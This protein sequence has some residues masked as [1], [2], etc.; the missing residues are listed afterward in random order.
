V[1]FISI[2]SVII[3]VVFFDACMRCTRLCPLKPGCDSSPSCGLRRSP[4]GPGGA[5]PR[6]PAAL[7]VAPDGA[8]A[9]P[10]SARPARPPGVLPVA[11][12]RPPASRPASRPRAARWLAPHVR[13]RWPR[14]P[15]A[16][17]RAPGV[18]SAFPCTQPQRARRSNLGLISF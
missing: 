16:P 5:A 2:H 9:R 14:A 17:A 3:Y 4:R 8:L 15:A 12:W 1:T 6:P 18:R 7:P 11:P 10:T 13:A